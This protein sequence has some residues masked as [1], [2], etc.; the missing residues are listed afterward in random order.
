MASLF[1]SFALSGIIPAVKHL[2]PDMT[3]A[4]VAIRPASRKDLEVIGDLWIELMT[5]HAGL[6]PRFGIPDNGRQHYI[7]HVTPMLRDDM[8]RVLVAEVAGAV[9]GYLLAYIAENPPIFLTHRY[10]FIADLCVTSFCRRRGVGKL[11]VD[12]AL[13]WFRLNDL[14]SIQLNVAHL[15]PVS[16]AFWRRIGCVDYLDHMWLKL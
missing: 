2:Q 10:G 12:A 6:D 14:S 13:R 8:C 5:F 7:K 3:E 11:L 9:V 1:A 15:N 4:P 16:Q